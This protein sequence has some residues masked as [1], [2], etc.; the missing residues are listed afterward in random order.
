ME[1]RYVCAQQVTRVTTKAQLQH[2][3]SKTFSAADLR[4][5]ADLKHE[6]GQ[7]LV[8][9]PLL[10]GRLHIRGVS[11]QGR[12]AA[13]AGKL[14]VKLSH[15]LKLLPEIL[16]NDLGPFYTNTHKVTFTAA[17]I[18]NT[19]RHNIEWKVKWYRLAKW[20]LETEKTQITC[21]P[22]H[23]SITCLFLTLV[24]VIAA[25]YAQVILIIHAERITGTEYL[26]KYP[27][28]S[29]FLLKIGTCKKI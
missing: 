23:G 6:H 1:R 11:R 18:S 19:R 15:L 25:W 2:F 20:S 5:W 3:N 27:K 7:L 24:S 4:A 29:S 22:M 17:K 21:S 16:G 8:V 13:L 10:H 9:F 26:A 12:A 28:T 14:S